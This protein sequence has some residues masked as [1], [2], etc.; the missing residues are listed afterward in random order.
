[1]FLWR[2]A[3]VLAVCLFLFVSGC[4]YTAPFTDA[5]GDI[6][7]ESIATMESVDVGGVA[8][9]IWFRAEDKRNPALILLHGG[10]G[11]SE[12]AL[13]RHYN[14]ELEKYFLVVYWEQRGAGRSY[15]SDLAPESMTI[16]QL[17]LDLDEVVALVKRRFHKDRVVLLGHSWGTALGT[18]YSFRHPENVSAY[19]GV[20]QIAN[21]EEGARLSCEFAMS[22]A[23][24]REDGHVLQDLHEICP[25][26]ESV[27]DRLML[28]RWV[29]R[30]GGMF[31]GDLSTG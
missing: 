17:I 18:M 25:S 10:P 12:S 14:A 19:V 1:M 8:Q 21:N 22:E 20:A 6:K 30:F 26:P 11:A 4:V 3:A 16:E 7:A 24:R 9:S 15:H 2:F 29:E 31:H 23:G 27:D 28:G 13:F 5:N